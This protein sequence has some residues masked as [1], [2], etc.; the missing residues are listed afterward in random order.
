MIRLVKLLVWIVIILVGIFGYKYYSFINSA[1]CY[2]GIGGVGYVTIKKGDTF[3]NAILYRYDSELF[4]KIYLKLNP[5]DFELQAGTYDIECWDIGSYIEQLKKPINESDEQV[6]FLEGWNIYDIDKTLAEKGLIESGAFTSY[7][8]TV[9]SFA[10]LKADYGFISDAETL[11]GFLYPDTYAI[12]PNSFSIEDLVRK[13]LARFQNKVID[14][15]I[16]SDMGSIEILDIITMASIVQKEA[17]KADNPEEIAI[18]AGILKKRVDE[19]W[20]IG[21]DATI[22]YAHGLATQ[23]CGPSEVFKYLYD[24]N[25]YNTRVIEGMPMGPIAN[26]EAEVIDATINSKSSPYYFY[27]HDNSGQIHYGETNADHERNKNQYLR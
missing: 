26:P 14:S 10:G 27:L 9:A 7:V 24:D 23:D 11:E 25:K 22:C 18:I 19:N 5:P 17:N 8:T 15:G 3:K 16:I 20:Q 2:D 6:T 1:T 12:N 4:T 13:M 21:A